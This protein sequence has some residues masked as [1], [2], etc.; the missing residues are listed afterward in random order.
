MKYTPH[1][2]SFSMTAARATIAGETMQEPAADYAA[3]LVLA[4]TSIAFRAPTFHFRHFDFAS[5]WAMRFADKRADA[6]LLEPYRAFH[7]V[8]SRHFRGCFMPQCA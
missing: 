2:D 6:E 5:H 3:A 4:P 1:T 8:I 7:D